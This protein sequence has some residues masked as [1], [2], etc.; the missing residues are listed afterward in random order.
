MAP[1]GNTS[2]GSADSRRNV[3]DSNAEGIV[4]H[5][6]P[7]RF[8]TADCDFGASEKPHSG[9]R[10]FLAAAGRGKCFLVIKRCALFPF[11]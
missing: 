7:Q 8:W 3:A 10:G 6:E 5:Y 2:P 1:T 4:S 11:L 9:R